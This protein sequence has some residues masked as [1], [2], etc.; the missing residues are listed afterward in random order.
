M[1]DKTPQNVL[2][3]QFIEIRTGLKPFPTQM[4]RL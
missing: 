3:I 1:R 2:L 4:V